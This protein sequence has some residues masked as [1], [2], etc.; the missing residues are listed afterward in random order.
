MT[1]AS[2]SDLMAKE[3]DGNTQSTSQYLLRYTC[4]L[5]HA[6]TLEY[7]VQAQLFQAKKD[8][9][10]KKKSCIEKKIRHLKRKRQDLKEEVFLLKSKD[11]EDDTTFTGL[12]STSSSLNL[13][14]PSISKEIDTIEQQIQNS[15][16]EKEKKL[17]EILQ[18]IPGIKNIQ[19]MIQRLR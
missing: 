12:T 18:E 6:Q 19:E 16:K 9:L 7:E 8:K 11:C 14:E 13:N 3:F 17:E 15:L 2:S 1:L 4:Q 5:L 10:E